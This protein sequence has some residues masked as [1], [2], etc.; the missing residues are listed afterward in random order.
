M[1]QSVFRWLR[2][3]NPL[4]SLTG[5]IF[6][7]FWVTLVVISMVSFLVLQQ[8]ARPYELTAINPEE[9]QILTFH[10]NEIEGYL[11]AGMTPLQAIR[12]ASNRFGLDLYLVDPNFRLLGSPQP[13]QLEL[14][15][16]GAMVE[17][18]TVT[19][20]T[21]E[22]VKWLGPSPVTYRGETY[23]LF[24]KA[25]VTTGSNRLIEVI[26]ERLTWTLLALLVSGMLSLWLANSLS[27]PLKLLRITSRSLASGRLESRVPS[28]VS[29]RADDIGQLGQD[30][31]HMA[32]R[33]QGLIEAQQKLLSNISHELRSPLTRL[34]IALGIARQ[35]AADDKSAPQLDRIEREAL[36]LEDMIA[37]LLQ[38]SRLE[39]R[40]QHMDL[41]T[42]DLGK[43]LRTIADDAQFEARANDRSVSLTLNHKSR[44]VGD[45]ML[46]SSAIENVVRN[47][48]KYT[49]AG[50]EVRIESSEGPGVVRVAVHDSGTGVPAQDLPYLFEAFF[51]ASNSRQGGSGLGLSIT[52]QAI[53]AHSGTVSAHNRDEGGLT[54]TLSLPVTQTLPAATTAQSNHS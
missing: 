28:T 46:L 35:R 17:A 30:F 29:K 53:E 54:I 22:D 14:Y 11:G 16:I 40:L 41:Q 44:V 19:T 18:D 5:R 9:Q 27:R 25:N 26:N 1:L 48:V 7:W 43:L 23:R 31:D 15:M 50:T 42:L 32:E 13:D 52:R 3:L 2:S 37:Q 6:L 47:A 33:I 51:R 36:R 39:N 21:W 12:Y 49:E 45:Q 10:Q 24:V 38:L 20:G 8:W 34:Q 4:A